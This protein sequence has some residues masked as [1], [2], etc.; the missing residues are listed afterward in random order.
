MVA[1]QCPRCGNVTD[2]T[3]DYPYCKACGLPF[4]FGQQQQYY[5]SPQQENP[6]DQTS[7][8]GV[9]DR[10]DDVAGRSANNL[11]V[12][13][14][15]ICDSCGYRVSKKA[16]SCPNCGAKR[17]KG[18]AKSKKVIGVL[19]A[20]IVIVLAVIFVAFA[21][22]GHVE[23][24][25]AKQETGKQAQQ[26]ESKQ[27]KQETSKQAQDEISIPIE[28]GIIGVWRSNDDCLAFDG[29]NLFYTKNGL[30]SPYT[31]DSESKKIKIA[32][33]NG[34][35]NVDALSGVSLTLSGDIR[36]TFKKTEEEASAYIAGNHIVLSP[37]LSWQNES[38]SITVN[39]FAYHAAGDIVMNHYGF[40]ET[41]DE[42]GY[43]V[44][45][46]FVNLSDATL[47]VEHEFSLNNGK[48]TASGS[49]K[50]MSLTPYSEDW[51]FFRYQVA[52][53]AKG[54]ISSIDLRIRVFERSAGT[55][56]YVTPWITI[57][58]A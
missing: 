41:Q 22:M 23:S 18:G 2:V 13:D 43:E 50:L 12:S 31:V 20:S 54:S 49:Y 36:G 28:G 34:S 40:E 44:D 10:V 35:I 29:T 51:S 8:V 4:T 11:N 38:V 58:Q 19:A 46:D 7:E 21:T 1:T 52:P 17:K 33:S 42:S 56:K 53:A 6:I 48:T 47:D 16:K 26:E 15:I 14:F 45:C 5:Q 37:G 39:S 27:T 9:S 3:P 30:Y 32:L 55:H 24:Q 57:K 25:P